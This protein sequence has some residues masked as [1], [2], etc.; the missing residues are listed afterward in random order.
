MTQTYATAS[1]NDDPFTR[2][3]RAIVQALMGDGPLMALVRPG[4]FLLHLDRSIVPKPSA[5]ESDLPEI[6]ILPAGVPLDGTPSDGSHWTQNYS[7]EVAAANLN[8]EPIHRIKW[9]MLR[10]FQRLRQTNMGLDGLVIHFRLLGMDEQLSEETGRKVGWGLVARVAIKFKV[11]D[12]EV[13]L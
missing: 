12:W 3:H 11:A 1:T 2:I 8:A 4:N 10:A 5:T 6:E 13:G 7:I 9:A